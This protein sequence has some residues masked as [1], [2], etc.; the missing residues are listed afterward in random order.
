M[1]LESNLI[2][3]Y[4]EAYRLALE[5]LR[6]CDAQEVCLNSRAIYEEQTNT[7]ILKYFGMEY[8]IDCIGG[9]VSPKK[10][11]NELS[12]TERV[13]MLHYLI[14][15]K[16][17]PLRGTYI[18]FIEVLGGGAIYY[19]TFKKRAIDPL[20]KVFSDNIQ[21]F[22]RAAYA[23]FGNRE[24]FGTKSFT[25]NAFPLVPVTFVLWQGDD[26]LASSGT[27]LFDA[28]ISEFLP[29]EDIVLVASF[30]AYKLI[31]FKDI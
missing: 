9:E 17:K 28:S 1:Q 16:P 24:K 3:A 15:A 6:K 13:L 22:E 31:G 8:K 18:S 7:Y 26:E 5:K 20:V 2:N 21:A 14:H 12:M 30:G 27:I 23:L 11:N 4:S 29:V 19:S 10:G 25:I